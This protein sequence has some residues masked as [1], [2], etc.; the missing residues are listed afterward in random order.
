LPAGPNL[1]R[2]PDR[3]TASLALLPN[4]SG[5]PGISDANGTYRRV[6]A[7][8][9]Y[10]NWTSLILG[11][12]GILAWMILIPWRTFVHRE[13]LW[14]PA[15]FALVSLLLPLPLFAMQPLVAIGDA[16]PAS[17]ALYA[18]TLALPILMAAQILWTVRNRH[19]T[20]AWPLQ[21]ALAVF[22]LQWCVVLAS[23]EMLP[24][25]TWR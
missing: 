23:W 1:Y 22:V 2:A 7:L 17:V 25:A 8:R 20:K 12:I 18:A 16:T 4:R 14:Q 5:A 13:R 9:Y 6:G 19:R 10:A 24:F 21:I 15:S 3:A 11:A